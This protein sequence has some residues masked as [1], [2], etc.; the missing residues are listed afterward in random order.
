MS[1][2]EHEPL[3]PPPQPIPPDAPLIDNKIAEET[4]AKREAARSARR[5]ALGVAVPDRVPDLLKPF[6]GGVQPDLLKIFESMLSEKFH[7]YGLR[8]DC[9]E[10]A[11]VFTVSTNEE[12]GVCEVSCK[13]CSKKLM[14]YDRSQSWGMPRPAGEDT[15]AYIHKCTCGSHSFILAVAV[16]YPQH[17]L[18]N[19]D[20]NSFMLAARCIVC[21][22]TS[23][24]YQDD[25]S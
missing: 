8:D 1:T 3:L 2:N 21:G 20:I 17:S 4:A 18:D 23:L 13:R 25:A 5:Q 19:N 11:R 9:H 14:L 6:L 22:A 10:L 15:T 12:A 24:I 16:D 7:A